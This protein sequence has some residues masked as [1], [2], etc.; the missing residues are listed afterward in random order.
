[1]SFRTRFLQEVASAPSKRDAEIVIDM[2]RDQLA[3]MAP[4]AKE[5]LLCQAADLIA[6]LPGETD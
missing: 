4:D 1:M 5:E 2:Y 3:A 6:E